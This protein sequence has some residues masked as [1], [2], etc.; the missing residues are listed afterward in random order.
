MDDL[1]GRG[2][3]V[4]GGSVM[5]EMNAL[6]APPGREAKMAGLK[7]KTVE[8]HPYFKRP[9]STYISFLRSLQS[10]KAKFLPTTM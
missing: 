4:A 2:G 10:W 7:P 1:I 8:L 6:F 9:G 5:D 3:V